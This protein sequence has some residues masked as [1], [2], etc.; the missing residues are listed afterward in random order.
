M[1]KVANIDE[2]GSR[3]E[4]CPRGDYVKDNSIKLCLQ[5]HKYLCRL[6]HLKTDDQHLNGTDPSIYNLVGAVMV[7]VSAVGKK[8]VGQST[9]G[10]KT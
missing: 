8:L 10:E 5:A 7:G 1:T 9:V 2:L 6:I 4:V 3:L